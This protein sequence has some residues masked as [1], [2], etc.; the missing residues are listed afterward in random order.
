[1]LL[2]RLE[3]AME[4]LVSYGVDGLTAEL[5]LDMAY[6]PADSAGPC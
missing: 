6:G 3:A 5:L 4:K 2:A 1:M